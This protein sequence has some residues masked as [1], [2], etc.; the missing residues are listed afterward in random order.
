MI[1][2]IKSKHQKSLDKKKLEFFNKLYTAG[3]RS[4]YVDLLGK[5]SERSTLSRIRLSAHK[6]A[7]ESGRYNSTLMKERCC[8]VCCTGAMEDETH[9]LLE[10]KAYINIRNMYLRNMHNITHKNIIFWAMKDSC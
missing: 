1:S 3:K 9:F 4:P 10:C 2:A 6:L 7:I 8:N 5:R